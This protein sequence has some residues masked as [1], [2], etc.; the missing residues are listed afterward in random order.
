MDIT[1]TIAPKSDQLN[2]DDLIAGPLTITITKVSKGSGPE[3]PVSISYE[4]DGGKPWKPCKGMRRVLTHVWGDEA[5][6]NAGTAYVGRG[7][8]L[9]RDEE[10]VYGGAKVSGIRIKAMSHIRERVTMALSVSKQKRIQFT[11]EPLATPRPA[12]APPAAQAAAASEPSS[13]AAHPASAKPWRISRPGK[14]DQVAPDSEKWLDW[15]RN[16]IRKFQTDG[17]TE[18]LRAL[19]TLNE[20]AWADTVTHGNPDAADAVAEIRGIAAAALGNKVE[21]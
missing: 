19:V 16:T 9:F 18:G 14:P 8:T 20:A 4:G 15:W 11:V 7:V 5:A 17:D 1:A 10:V 12:K 21:E 13:E 6:R 3:Q 2:S